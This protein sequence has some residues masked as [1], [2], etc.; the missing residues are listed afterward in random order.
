M[1]T[2]ILL[3]TISACMESALLISCQSS[4]NKVEN[5]ENKLEQARYNL[6]EAAAHLNKAKKDS[7]IDYLVF[8]DESEKRIKEYEKDIADLKDKLEN[9]KLEDQYKIE[10]KLT[11]L[12][13]KNNDLKRKLQ[14]S[15]EVGIYKWEIYK[16]EIT[17][18]L[19][20]IGRSIK[21]LTTKISRKVTSI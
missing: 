9:E 15:K 17:N 6:E 21:N 1:K 18:N 16:A 3:I 8:K 13:Q 14:Y 11:E 19:D 20:D 7:M 10:E 5:A 4:A 2:T 12:E